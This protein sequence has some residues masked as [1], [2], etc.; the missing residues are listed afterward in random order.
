MRAYVRV[1]LKDRFEEKVMTI[2]W[3]GCWLWTGQLIGGY[4]IIH[5]DS[6]VSKARKAHR[7]SYE[8]YNGPIPNG[9]CVLHRCDVPCCVNP[10]HLFLGDRIENNRDRHQKGRSGCHSGTKNGRAKLAWD[11][12]VKIRLDKRPTCD[13][14]AEFMVCKSTVIR[15]RNGTYCPIRKQPE[16]M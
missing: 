16:S 14:A 12:A 5:D 7:I 4:G 1:P 8:I 11:K 3:T 13:V 9:L 2:P 15:I 10:E 6:R